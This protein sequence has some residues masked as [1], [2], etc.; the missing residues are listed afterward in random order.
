MLA[1]QGDEAGGSKSLEPEK[2]K[3]ITM[4]TAEPR[5]SRWYV[6]WWWWW[7]SGRMMGNYRWFLLLCELGDREI[8]AI[9]SQSYLFWYLGDIKG[10]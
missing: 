7:G 10:T 6:W 4:I 9:H 5:I 1:S 3:A 2:G 8:R